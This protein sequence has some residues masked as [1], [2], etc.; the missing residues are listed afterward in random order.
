MAVS[1]KAVMR[2]TLQVECEP[3]SR[4]LYDVKVNGEPTDFQVVNETWMGALET[5]RVE[6]MKR[7]T[8]NA[9]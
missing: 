5:A 9:C 8:G 4:H 3:V 1:V 7:I 6:V 2:L